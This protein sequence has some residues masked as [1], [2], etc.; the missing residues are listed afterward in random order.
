MTGDVSN[1]KQENQGLIDRALFRLFGDDNLSRL[2]NAYLVLV[3]VN[4]MIGM[5]FTYNNFWKKPDDFLDLETMIIY[6]VT[7]GIFV[8]FAKFAERRRSRTW[9][10]PIIALYL[11]SIIF[12][13]FNFN[14][15]IL[16]PFN[17]LQNFYSKGGSGLRLVVIVAAAWDLVLAYLVEMI[18]LFRIF[19]NIKAFK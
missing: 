18:V 12:I 10:Y 9:L 3:A 4:L 14:D 17:V 7:F 1:K 2:V 5:V 15:S 19:L 11:I 13:I 16:T 8:F 6:V